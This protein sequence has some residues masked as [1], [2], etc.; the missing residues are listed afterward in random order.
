MAMPSAP[1]ASSA[2]EKVPLTAMQQGMLYEWAAAPD[3]SNNLMQIVWRID[4]P[5]DEARLR[6]AWQAVTDRHE[7][8]RLCFRRSAN[9]AEQAVQDGFRIP[10]RR[11]ILEDHE[12]LKTW[13]ATDRREN[14]ALAG[15]QPPTRWTFVEH[16]DAASVV[17]TFHH[18]ILD[19]RSFAIVLDD[20]RRIYAGESLGPVA[21]PFTEWVLRRPVDRARAE[22]F[23]SKV[24]DGYT[25]TALPQ[26]VRT[27]NEAKANPGGRSERQATL[28][29]QEVEALATFAAA[30]EVTLHT[31]FQAAWGLVLGA[32]SDRPD[33]VFGSVRACRHAVQNSQDTVGNLIHTVPVRVQTQAESVQELLRRLR[34]VQ[35]D[36][37]P[38]ETTPLHELR[39]WQDIP[40]DKRMHS[41]LMYEEGSLQELLE[42]MHPDWGRDVVSLHQ[43][44]RFPLALSVYRGPAGAELVLEFDRSRY[45]DAT[46]KRLLA[47]TVTVLKEL[48]Q[49]AQRS[50]LSL[51]VVSPPEQHR[52][53]ESCQG[54]QREGAA[55]LMLAQIASNAQTQGAN[56]AVEYGALSW[57]YETLDADSAALAQH[58]QQSFG[59]VDRRFIGICL[60]P[61]YDLI[62]ALL[63]ILRTGAAYV[64]LDPAYPEERIAAMIEDTELAG[65]ISTRPIFA[66]LP[67]QGP[68]IALDEVDLSHGVPNASLPTVGPEHTAVSIFT[69]GTTGRPKGVALSH[70]ALAE[71]NRSVRERLG[72]EPRDRVPQLATINFDVAIE[73]IFA[74]LCAGGTLVFA[75]YGVLATLQKLLGFI[76]QKELSVLN[77]TTL[78]WHQIVLHLY[79]RKEQMPDCVRCVVVGGER[80]T[81]AMYRRWQA[82]GGDRIQW[83]NAYGPTENCPM[84]TY[85]APPPGTEL[86][87]HP[88]IGRPLPN[89]S[90]TVIDALGRI[91]P[92]G[93]VG[94][95]WL[96]G[97]QLAEGYIQSPE[98]TEAKFPTRPLWSDT[99]ERLYRTGDLAWLG[100]DGELRYTSRADSQIK[101]RGFRIEPGEVESAAESHPGIEVCFVTASPTESGERALVAYVKAAAGHSITSEDV[102]AHI[103]ERVPPFMRPQH[104]VFIDSLPRS[105]NGKVD[106]D[107]LPTL[108]LQA[109]PSGPKA[110]PEDDFEA[111]MLRLWCE[112]LRRSDI[113]MDDDFFSLGGDSLKAMVLS[114][115]VEE[116]FDRTVPLALLLD[117]S[118]VRRYAEYVRHATKDQDWTPIVRMA[119]GAPPALF[120][121]HSLGGD[122]LN[123]RDL[124]AEIGGAAYGIQMYGLDQRQA[125][126]RD[127][128]RAARDYISVMTSVQPKG[129]YVLAGFSSG[130]IIAFEMAW[131]LVAAGERVAELIL[132]DSGLPPRAE[133]RIQ[134]GRRARARAVVANLP[135]VAR[136][137]RHWDQKRWR[138][139]IRSAVESARERLRSKTSAGL[140][141]NPAEHFAH[142]ISFF[143]PYR[144]EL[145]KTHYEAI[146]KYEPPDTPLDIKVRLFR[147]RRQ[148]LLK[149]APA[150]LGWSALTRQPI[151]IEY[152]G[153]NHAH[154]LE[155]PFVESIGRSIRAGLTALRNEPQT[156][157][158]PSAEAETSPTGATP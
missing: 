88:P 153:A 122:I 23:W 78:L 11:T 30:S 92:I 112:V 87:E 17:W 155:R 74:T 149:P 34:G 71:H 113:G 65:V 3:S 69:S 9:G 124:V 128:G 60:A 89:T 86:R 31:L 80:S 117:A 12:S 152:V 6:N 61:S 50:I 76:A 95:L 13:L 107:K 118:T 42:S 119:E 154:M 156:S 28:P 68:R 147:P 51:P 126:H 141:F 25:G 131:Q 110:R 115:R 114:G 67:W 48:R 142:D 16:A 64:P 132:L 47:A 15:E 158:S 151:Q 93:V 123:Y 127:I 14:F 38:V 2:S 143:P 62:R 57:S 40:A 32:R 136:D 8:L 109:T 116:T 145:M 35:L 83:V 36:V 82:V 1:G 133:S 5:V 39:A 130:G 157:G 72:L 97:A 150:D 106:R 102:L 75:E 20:V 73:E 138:G 70:G 111:E 54:R 24:L 44:S 59:P 148:P 94:E 129:P 49:D 66:K 121:I 100:A 10:W 125:P 104:L 43:E 45:E 26:P 134:F 22:A 85:Y 18:I 140:A 53:A 41:F 105:P 137:L 84:S 79:E 96:G 120:L 21:T 56:P 27:K 37:R 19:G 139:A 99:P 58:V 46:A 63:A 98:K 7:A 101:I 108:K 77:L 90:A 146:L 144:I 52:I 81:E 91:A 55:P 4:G 135:H 33:V 29:A 103:A